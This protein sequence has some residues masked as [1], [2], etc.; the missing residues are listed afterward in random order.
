VTGREAIEGGCGGGRGARPTCGGSGSF[1]G[2][3][4]DTKMSIPGIS[5]FPVRLFGVGVS[6][7][8]L[9][10]VRSV[11]R[12]MG[13]ALEAGPVPMKM[14]TRAHNQSTFPRAKWHRCFGA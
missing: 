9:S 10:T 2:S 11:A 5:D 7:F 1:S 12:L 4:V 13:R 14:Q 6:N 3:A 8:S